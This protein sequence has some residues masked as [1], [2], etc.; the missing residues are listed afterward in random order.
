MLHRLKLVTLTAA[1]MLLL[2]QASAFAQEAAK[3]AP[4][5][6][7]LYIE[8]TNL[9]Q[10]RADWEA[11]P[12]S[13][14]VKKQMPGNRQPKAWALIQAAL[15]MPGPQVIDTFLGSKVAL[16]GKSPD[17]TAEGKDQP[18]VLVTR[19]SPDDFNIAKA[20]LDLV[21][22]GKS[23]DFNLFTSG[24][25]TVNAAFNNAWLILA[26]KEHKAYL[27]EVL[28]QPAASGSLADDASFKAWVAKLPADR[29][30]MIYAHSAA[31]QEHHALAIKRTGKGLTMHYAGTPRDFATKTEDVAA[32]AP[33]DFGPLPASTVAATSVNMLGDRF[34]NNPR[35]LD[36]L[37][38]PKTFD[39]DVRPHIASPIILFHAGVPGSSLENDPG[40]T[41]PVVGA[42]VKMTD[43]KIAPD[44]QRIFDGLMLWANVSTSN[45]GV[46]MITTETVDGY[47]V[48]NV[49]QPLAERAKRDE[50]KPLRFVYGQ[51]GDWYV[52]CTSQQ[53]FEQCRAV[54]A[55]NA[56]PFNASAGGA[57]EGTPVMTM[58]M[59][60]A[61]LDSEVSNW[62]AYLEKNHPNLL[63][64][65]PAERDDDRRARIVNAMRLIDAIADHYSG[66][67][68]QVTRTE[69]G[70]ARAIIEAVRK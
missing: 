63:V 38:A 37:L 9:K 47:R 29:S 51:V 14:I 22:A 59:Q 24:D 7:G 30:A 17:K 65:N 62:L 21:D 19:V 57:I 2:T 4:K 26:G 42:M 27:D 8:V 18:S 54:A 61:L 35:M 68:M 6:A 23:G 64:D 15:G 48:A 49:G 66:M 36:R 60:P 31:K 52:V 67:H 10:L 55:G 44:L 34:A 12:L 41:V 69:N 20:R 11:D 70:E 45:W 5:D 33:V 56:K 39:A 16:I 58:K 43:A 50:L 13:D 32:D 3:L 1:A 46:S 28:K 40:F 25:N 53:F